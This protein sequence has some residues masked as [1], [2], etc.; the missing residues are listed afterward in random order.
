MPLRLRREQLRAIELE[1]HPEQ[2]PAY[3]GHLRRA[4]PDRLR[5]LGDDAL[6]ERVEALL[7]RARALGVHQPPDDLRLLNLAACFGWSFDR[8]VP[9]VEPMLRDAAIST[10]SER[11]RRVKARFVRQLQLQ[12]RNAEVRRTFGPIDG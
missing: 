9:W 5:E 2:V 11:L 7:L 6:R 3:L 1:L 8:D 4:F 12:A 10:V